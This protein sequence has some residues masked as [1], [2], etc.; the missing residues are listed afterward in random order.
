MSAAI[1]VGGAVGMVVVLT[2][3]GETVVTGFEGCAITPLDWD[4]FT[5]DSVAELTAPPPAAEATSSVAKPLE[6]VVK[7]IVVVEVAGI[8][9]V[10]VD[11]IVVI[12]EILVCTETAG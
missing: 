10:V 8:D 11:S 1:V 9:V 2:D 4:R 12:G 3:G 5:V 6:V 7:L